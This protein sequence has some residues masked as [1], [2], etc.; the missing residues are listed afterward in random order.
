MGS[1]FLYNSGA[2]ST[3]ID[4]LQ[5][6]FLNGGGTTAL[7]INNSGEVVGEYQ[8]ND[9][10]SNFLYSDG[11]YTT[12]NDPLLAS[13]VTAWSGINNN[14]DMIGTYY[15][16]NG[17]HG[18]LAVAGPPASSDYGSKSN[19]GYAAEPVNTALGNY[20]Y[21]HT[22]LKLSG[23]PGLE[24]TR[25]Y[26]SQDTYQGPLGYGWTDSYNISLT[27]SGST[28]A[29]KYGDG[30]VEQ[31]T[32]NGNGI[33]TPKWGGI[34][35]TLVQNQD[36]TYTI[37]NKAQTV[38]NFASNG[39]LTSIVDKNGNAVS[40]VY[41]GGNLTSVAGSNGRTLSF[42]YDSSNRITS[43]TDPLGRTV[44]YTYDAN[45][46]LASCT[47][48]DGGKWSYQYD[49]SHEIAQILNPLGNVLVANT[50]ES[51]KVVS[52]ADGLG[53]ITTFQYDTPSSGDTTV[54]DPMGRKTVYG[55]DSKY[56]LTQLVNPLGQ[57]VSYAY[58]A[59]EDLTSVTDVRGNITLYTY[60][61]MGNVTS[62]TD[63]LGDVISITYDVWNDPLTVTDALGNKTTFTYDSKGNLLTAT[64]ALGDVT[65]FTYTSTGQ[66]SSI[67]NA[68]NNSTTFSYDSAGD[69]L[70]AKNP[71]GDSTGY[72]YDA[73][74]RKLSVTDANGQKTSYAYD[75]DDNT[76]SVTDP[77]G[78]AATFAY[79]AD[80]NLIS[81]TD[82]NGVTTSYAYNVLNKAVSIDSP[83]TGTT[84]LTYDPDGE[85]QTRTDANGITRTYGYDAGG[86]LTSITF[87][88]AG[89]NVAL[90]YDASASQTGFLTGVT[91]PS[92]VTTYQYDAL[93]RMIQ[94]QATILGIVYTTSYQY[95]KDGN[96]VSET[97]PDGRQ[98]AYAFNAV[99]FPINVNETALKKKVAPVASAISYDKVGNILTLTYGNGLIMQRAYDATNRI[100]QM[101]VPGVLN[102]S[103]ARDPLGNITGIT[104]L[105]KSS[106]SQAFGYDPL[107]QLLSAQGPWGN[108]AYTYDANGNRLS[109]ALN[110]EVGNYAY[111]GNQLLSV[112]DGNTE[113]FQYDK[114]GNITGDGNLSFVYNESNH[115]AEVMNGTTVLGQYIYNGN[116]QR[117]EKTVPANGA[118][119]FH[120]DLAGRLIEE[121]SANGKLIADYI[122]LGRNPLAM[123]SQVA[124]QEQI[125]FYHDDHLGSPKFMTD[126]TK[127]IVWASSFD[128]FGNIVSASGSVTNNLRFP[129][130]YYDQ[131]TGLSYN[132]N[133][134]YDPKI[135]RYTQPDPVGLLG[136]MNRYGY[137]QNDPVNLVDPNGQF[138]QIIAGALGGGI[139]GGIT[140]AIVGFASTYAT[141]GS[142]TQAVEGGL[143][144]SVA[145]AASGAIAGGLTAAGL[146]E[147]GLSAAELAGSSI[148]GEGFLSGVWSGS[149]ESLAGPVGSIFGMLGSILGPPTTPAYGAPNSASCQ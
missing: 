100:S 23:D 87:P 40:L 9:G 19:S 121:T 114:D 132:Y 124:K 143:T 52:Q 106:N 102:L 43:I 141:S 79:D 44:S 98:V 136:G 39:Q 89:Q 76:I 46:N 25:T 84:T 69:L 37:T 138:I 58:D 113:S 78:K 82:K 5:A 47:D 4:P 2:Y 53:N 140:G 66:I 31:Y 1:V 65:T 64:D 71:L 48:A 88:D 85:V 109:G 130:Q 59:N 28:V 105:M 21:Q 119:I 108:Q 61:A 93:G 147:L 128:P 122:Y 34:Y 118:T 94:K 83:D 14:G 115:L 95:D 3:L 127:N 38:Y 120:Y 81:A 51:S 10:S 92:G 20:V 104:D 16:S 90:S 86:R 146:P 110:A 80:N 8:G 97:Y 55:H 126:Q 18:L 54:T 149:A 135:G 60:D 67:T 57:T 72:T 145:G 36:G 6:S 24:F 96:L 68:N 41:T 148:W 22:D 32:S 116:G 125:Y 99:N 49:S 35:S 91:D 74:G 123:I 13:P 101:N 107:Y 131:E 112:S 137:V 117:V 33:F 50:Y 17:A 111:Q 12:I 27:V 103:Y 7:G 11:A 45:G 133:R 56:E 63:P 62:K 73:A 15:D 77:D 30:H 134:Y 144:G 75:G 29:V 42:N 70:E 142:L 129:G 26:N 139:A